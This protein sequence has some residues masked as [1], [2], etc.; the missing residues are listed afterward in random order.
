MI[1]GIVR[2]FRG[3]KIRYVV[4]I[5]ENTAYLMGNTILVV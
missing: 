3:P 4:G 5:G 2:L 1:K